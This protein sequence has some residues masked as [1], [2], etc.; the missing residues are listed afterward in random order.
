MY[1]YKVIQFFIVMVG[2]GCFMCSVFLNQIFCI[3]TDTF[4]LRICCIIC[5]CCCLCND[6]DHVWFH[7]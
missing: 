4:L 3:I 1:V 5:C 6:C 2:F 7:V